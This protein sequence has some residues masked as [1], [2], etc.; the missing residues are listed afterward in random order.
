M[1]L[2]W[3]DDQ[4]FVEGADEDEETG[5][6]ND[7]SFEEVPSGWLEPC[8]WNVSGFGRWSRRENIL[9]LEARAW[10]KCVERLWARNAVNSFLVTTCSGIDSV[11]LEVATLCTHRHPSPRSCLHSC[12]RHGHCVKVDNE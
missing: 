5:F 12:T 8:R 11:S 3:D 4:W 9:V 2:V 6:N 7:P 10:M 1:D